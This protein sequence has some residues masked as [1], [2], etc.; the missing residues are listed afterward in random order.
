[1]LQR[2]FRCQ[3]VLCRQVSGVSHNVMN[4]AGLFRLLL[5]WAGPDSICSHCTNPA[6]THPFFRSI[7]FKGH[8]ACARSSALQARGST[9][10]MD[11]CLN[12]RGA[13]PGFHCASFFSRSMASGL[14]S[15]KIWHQSI[16]SV[17]LKQ[18][19]T[20]FDTFRALRRGY[21]HLI[22]TVSLGKRAKGKVRPCYMP[23][24]QMQEDVQVTR[25]ICVQSLRSSSSCTPCGSRAAV[26]Q[27]ARR[28]GGCC[29]ES[30]PGGPAGQYPTPLETAGTSLQQHASVI[31]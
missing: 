30:P 13:I 24:G 23:L 31:A 17:S 4:S 26:A 2:L 19:C 5:L 21:C 3:A 22:G 15:G 18:S 27:A 11:T 29:P 10:L 8:T 1:M 6:S 14:A 25:Q 7:L 12:K 16:G 28:A 20:R 9:C